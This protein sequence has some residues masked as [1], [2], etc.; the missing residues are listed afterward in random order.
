[1]YIRDLEPPRTLPLEEV[2]VRI[3]RDLVR[4]AEAQRVTDWVEQAMTRYE[5]LRS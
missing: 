5:V 4:E 1:V 2:S 3:E